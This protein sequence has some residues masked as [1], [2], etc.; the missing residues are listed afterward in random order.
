MNVA[1]GFAKH[2]DVTDLNFDRRPYD[3]K[4]GILPPFPFL[5]FID[6]IKLLFSYFFR[7]WDHSAL[8]CHRIVLSL[9]TLL[10]LLPSYLSQ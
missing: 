3:V 5:S 4:E 10:S 2:L 7:S 8:F 9:S 6:I 1:S